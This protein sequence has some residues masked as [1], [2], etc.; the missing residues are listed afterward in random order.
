MVN[1]E[2]I[3]NCVVFE[4]DIDF[5]VSNVFLVVIFVFVV[6]GWDDENVDEFG[7]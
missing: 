7:D 3:I 1:R 2:V 4:N 6:D 5:G